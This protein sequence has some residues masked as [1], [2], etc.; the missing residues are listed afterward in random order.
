MEAPKLN[1]PSVKLKYQFTDG[2]LRVYDSL[3]RKYVAVTPEEYVRQHFTAWLQNFMH[4]PAS[5]MANEVGIEV[6]GTRK[7]CDTVIFDRDGHPLM[8]CEY[9][10]P[11]I[12][13][14]QDVFDQAVRYNLSLQARYI[15]VS[16]GLQHYCCRINLKDATYQFIPQIPDYREIINPL[17]SN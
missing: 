14:T 8:V 17:S 13:I 9:K 6:N 10:A 15:V 11:T 4:Y 16:N 2:I 3:R 7:R 1:L 12:R 5:M